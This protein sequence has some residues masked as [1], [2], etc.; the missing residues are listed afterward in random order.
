MLDGWHVMMPMSWMYPPVKSTIRNVLTPGLWLTAIVTPLSFWLASSAGSLNLAFFAAGCV[1]PLI[2]LAAFVGFILKDP[3]R[4]LT[5]ETQVQNLLTRTFGQSAQTGNEAAAII[6]ASRRD[7]RLAN[8]MT[9]P[10]QHPT[11]Y[12]TRGENNE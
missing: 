8:E 3:S 2:T 4:L 7:P 1:P 12:Y 11:T 5:E 6:E 9:N 10:Y